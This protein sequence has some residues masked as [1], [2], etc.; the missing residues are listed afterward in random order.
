MIIIGAISI[1]NRY[2]LTY[3]IWNQ[4]WWHKVSKQSLDTKK[5]QFTRFQEN[6]FPSQNWLKINNPWYVNDERFL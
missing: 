2:D 6:R 4:R 1:I 3:C 5:A